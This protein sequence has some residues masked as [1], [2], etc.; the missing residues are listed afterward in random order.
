MA[1]EV[2]DVCDLPRGADFFVSFFFTVPKS[3]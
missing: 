2:A 1:A 3:K